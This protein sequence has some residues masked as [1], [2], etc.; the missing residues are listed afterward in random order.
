VQDKYRLD[1]FYGRE[2]PPRVH[3]VRE[4]KRVDY[5]KAADEEYEFEF[6]QGE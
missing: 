1:H 2:A 4:R 3:Y 5:G 6:L